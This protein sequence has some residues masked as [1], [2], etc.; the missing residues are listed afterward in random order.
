MKQNNIKNVK[1]NYYVEEMVKLN[2][3]M[4]NAG[5]VTNFITIKHKNMIKC[6][7]WVSKSK[8][9]IIRN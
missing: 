8:I 2:N 1:I 9:D 3:L 5:T 7:H 6:L 4:I